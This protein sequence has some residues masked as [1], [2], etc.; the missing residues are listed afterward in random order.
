MRRIY[1][2]HAAATPIDSDVLEVMRSVAA[3][4]Y[5][6]P[7]SIHAEGVAAKKVLDASRATIAQILGVASPGVIF[8]ASG[9][10]S[11]NIAIQGV[12]KA[13]LRDYTRP[14]VVTSMI[15]HA[16]VLE[17]VRTLEK[18]GMIE[19]TY[20]SCD[21]NG[22]INPRD[23]KDALKENTVLVSIMYANSE[24]GT[25]QPIKDIVR[26]VREYRTGAS[27]YPFVHTDACQAVNYLPVS[28]EKLG[29][30]L[31]TINASKMYG[32]KGVGVLA[33]REGVRLTPLV[34]GGGQELGVRSGTESVVHIA[35]MA[36][37]LEKT[38]DVKDVEGERLTALRDLFFSDIEKRFGGVVKPHGH[39]IERLP[40]NV[41]ISIPD[42]ENDMLVIELDAKGVA[43][44]SK[45][46]C[47][48][49]SGDGSHVLKAMGVAE[50]RSTLRFSLGR[51][52]T[53]ED[54]EYT[55]GALCD[56]LEKYR[57]ITKD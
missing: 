22:L 11:D 38:E 34:F 52:T 14:H 18:I 13:S 23:V 29:V 25:V 39:R 19:A 27:P 56:I 30:D 32:P 45:S 1:L 47:K 31:L 44:S 26:L 57:V 21:E 51:S 50:N 33:L 28:M 53:R 42:L 41:H 55:V 20:L 9:T 54:V 24:V 12:V 5:G 46:A 48:S 15:E 10:E 49:S 4:I 37:A 16:A 36:R 17:T 3:D 6:N 40:N 2:D 8:T 7:S 35:A 43:C